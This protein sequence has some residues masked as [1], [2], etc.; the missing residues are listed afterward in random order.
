MTVLIQYRASWSFIWSLYWNQIRD[1]TN[2]LLFR[3]AVWL[4]GPLTMVLYSK[5]QQEGTENIVNLDLCACLE[6]FRAHALIKIHNYFLHGICHNSDMFWSILIIFSELL[7]INKTYKQTWIIKYIEICA[8]CILCTN[9]NVF[10]NQCLYILL[11]YSVTPWSWS[12]WIE[13]CRSFD[14][15]YIKNILT[16]VHFVALLCELCACITSV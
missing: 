6:G 2:S 9:V 8:K 11:W 5:W 15:L 1:E 12:R 7:N 3:N 16:L 4:S 10:N 14:K 13:T